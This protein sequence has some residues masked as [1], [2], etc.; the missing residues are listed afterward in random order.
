MPLFK[1]TTP[2]LSVFSSFKGTEHSER[3]RN[4]YEE[5]QTFK[6]QLIKAEAALKI[7]E[8]GTTEVLK[9]TDDSMTAFPRVWRKDD[10]PATSPNAAVLPSEDVDKPAPTTKKLAS[11]PS[12]KFQITMNQRL[13]DEVYTPI[14]VWHKQ[15]K[16]LKERIDAVESSR[17][18]YDSSRKELA[19]AR[20]AQLK[21]ARKTDGKVDA[22]LQAHEAQA[23]SILAAKREA[24]ITIEEEVHTE[25]LALAAD[26]QKTLG[27][28]S[29]ALL[30]VAEAL[31]D[32]AETHRE[33]ESAMPMIN[34]QSSGPLQL[35]VG[36]SIMGSPVG[37][38]AGT[39]VG[40]PTYA[41]G[42][43]AFGRA[44]DSSPE[45]VARNAQSFK[46]TTTPT[47]FS[48]EA[49]SGKFDEAA[50]YQAEQGKTSAAVDTSGT[51]EG[52]ANLRMGEAYPAAPT[53]KAGNIQDSANEF[54]TAPGHAA[55]PAGE[56]G[57]FE[58]KR[59]AFLEQHAA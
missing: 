45:A 48:N 42:S 11:Y 15:Y 17:I 25:S 57:N 50:A 51:T 27:Y 46:S 56:K 12:H 52:V 53:H 36:S 5:T 59:A 7:Y 23:E 55:T 33:R 20:E 16:H 9:V 31:A 54:P 2:G 49:G 29:R 30:L 14:E 21:H 4:T 19:S 43:P 26:A 1:K 47:R 32:A 35:G 10:A 44:G 58:D 39:P 40:T 28:V 38:P 8:K 34:R 41:S 13:Q 3:L 24:Y 37:S 18:E 22:T 6:R